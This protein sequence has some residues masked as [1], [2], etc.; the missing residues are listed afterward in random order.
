MVVK[1]SLLILLFLFSSVDGY[2]SSALGIEEIPAETREPAS[3]D[4][5]LP[6]QA[7]EDL[8]KETQQQAEQEATE[9]E[10][11]QLSKEESNYTSSGCKLYLEKA[12]AGHI[13]A[14]KELGD[15]A[16][17]ASQF[18]G[19]GGTNV[20]ASCKTA[21]GNGIQKFKAL[22]TMRKICGDRFNVCKS[23][24]VT[25]T[26]LAVMRSKY[27]LDCGFFKKKAGYWGAQQ[28]QAKA[29]IE[30]SMS[31]DIS[32]I[33]EG[34]EVTTEAGQESSSLMDPSAKT[35]DYNSFHKDGLGQGEV[36][37][38]GDNLVSDGFEPVGGENAVKVADLDGEP[39]GMDN[40]VKDVNAGDVIESD[41]L[42]TYKVADVKSVG[43]GEMTDGQLNTM[44]DDTPMALQKHKLKGGNIF[45]ENG[46]IID[47]AY[48]TVMSPEP[49]GTAET[50]T[51]MSDAEYAEYY[52]SQFAGADNGLASAP[53]EVGSD[54]KIDWQK[55]HEDQYG[56]EVYQDYLKSISDGVRGES[57]LGGSGSN[58]STLQ[59]QNRTPKKAANIEGGKIIDD[60]SGGK[61]IIDDGG[62]GQQ[63][64][65]GNE[66]TAG[67]VDGE[68]NIT[69]DNQ[70][71]SVGNNNNSNQAMQQAA[72]Q[73]AGGQQ[74]QGNSNSGNSG[75]NF[76]N[77]SSSFPK[78]DNKLAEVENPKVEESNIGNSS[79]KS[80]GVQQ[81][82]SQ[83]NFNGGGQQVA[84][85]S[86]N[87]NFSG[88]ESS[89]RPKGTY[90]VTA[91]GGG[92]PEGSSGGPIP[93]G[94][95]SAN[96]P[97]PF[98]AAK[99]QKAAKDEKSNTVTSSVSSGGGGGGYSYASGDNPDSGSDGDS[100]GTS[101]CQAMGT[102]A[103][104]VEDDGQSLI[105]KMQNQLNSWMGW[106]GRGS[107]KAI[108]DFKGG[109]SKTKEGGTVYQ[110]PSKPRHVTNWM[111]SSLHL[112]KRCKITNCESPAE[113]LDDS[114]VSPSAPSEPLLR[115]PASKNSG[116]KGASL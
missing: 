48:Q 71:A 78:F 56:Q 22:G 6:P 58:V 13:K 32:S 47:S 23:R 90:K 24:C 81:T 91:G 72:Q 63:Q 38:L 95:S 34:G 65:A 46:Q 101:F 66:N 42:G 111:A 74:G 33:A 107:G 76:G 7:M 70:T 49:L 112:R 19:G 89:S 28:L 60:G 55:F 83:A 109:I 36:Q 31:C 44:L 2:A 68:T 82:A 108:Y 64:I 18:S 41:T 20:N 85:V 1:S 69:G 54:G 75:S 39:Q 43:V 29:E 116:T 10:S 84:A 102:C 25:S 80:E 97:N 15:P 52:N 8:V 14:C 4:P 92:T 57:L 53:M 62:G 21:A 40:L 87:Y 103:G 61:K 26:D 100:G 93:G 99:V 5:P 98:G 113:P 115:I 77:G 67:T 51:F 30:Q 35:K 27:G 17:L 106:M 59:T 73:M 94:E 86:P 50:S 45:D 96:G 88:V 9:S 104:A 37:Q 3:V 114:G 11:K 105:A 16:A 79:S 110:I 12:A